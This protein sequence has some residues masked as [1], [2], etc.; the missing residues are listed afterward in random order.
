MAS[1]VVRRLMVLG[2]ILALPVIGIAQ[3]AVL[4]GT[5][6]DSTGAVL[7]GVDRH[8]RARG[9]RQQLR[10]GHRRARASIGSPC[11]SAPT[12]SPRSFRASRTVTRTA[13]ELLVGQTAVDQPA[14]GAVDGRR[15]R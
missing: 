6:T 13:C 4:T 5:V 8:G 14:D 10:G 3:E 12:R 2:A 7:P 11:A 15:K 1:D 9:H